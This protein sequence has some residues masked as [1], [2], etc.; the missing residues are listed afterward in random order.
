MHAAC[1]KVSWVPQMGRCHGCRSQVSVLL[2]ISR[3][4]WCVTNLHLWL[5]CLR[6]LVLLPAPFPNPF[7][8][9]SSCLLTIPSSLPG[10]I[11]MDNKLAL[12]PILI[13]IL[14]LLPESALHFMHQWVFKVTS[15]NI[16]FL[17]Q[18]LG[19]YLWFLDLKW[20]C[21]STSLLDHILLPFYPQFP[22]L[23]LLHL[24]PWRMSLIISMST[25]AP[26]K[27]TPITWQHCNF[28]AQKT[29]NSTLLSK[30]GCVGLAW[31]KS[32]WNNTQDESYDVNAYVMCVCDVG[33]KIVLRYT[34]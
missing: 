14:S 28:S 2:L 20:F 24:V 30:N 21:A 5:D 22:F 9:L 16:Y 6:C 13:L 3:L 23:T 33:S 12:L 7:Q 18:T 34:S 8:S 11:S 10:N 19:W 25:V 31:G 15:K 32:S 17:L 4:W 26:L 29:Q 1:V 27:R